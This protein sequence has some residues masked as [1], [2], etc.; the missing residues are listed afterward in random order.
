MEITKHGNNECIDP[1]KFCTVASTCMAIYKHLFLKPNTI[2]LVP[3][4]GMICKDQYSKISLCWLDYLMFKDPNLKIQHAGNGSEYRYKNYRFDG[5]V[6]PNV[7]NEHKGTVFEFLGCKFHAHP[8][9]VNTK[10]KLY[11]KDI[12]TKTIERQKELENDVKEIKAL[13]SQKIKVSGTCII[14]R[15]LKTFCFVFTPSAWHI[16]NDL[17]PF[18]RVKRVAYPGFEPPTGSVSKTFVSVFTTVFCLT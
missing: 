15:V 3:N 7:E 18:V 13:E 14:L 1:L 11:L 10:N 17:E 2:P 4:D 6:P 5:Y 16:S 8:E 12:Y 9:C